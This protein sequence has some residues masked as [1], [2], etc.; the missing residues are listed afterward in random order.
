MVHAVGGLLHVDAVQGPGKIVCDIGALGADLMT[1]SAHKL[2]GPKGV[3][4]VVTRRD[5]HLTDPMIRGGGQERGARAG[6]ENVAGIAGFGAAAAAAGEGLAEAGAHMAALRERL[7]AGLRAISPDTALFGASVARLPNTASFAVP[8]MKAETA[9]IALDL[10]GLAVSS[11]SACSS[12]KVSASHVLAAMGVE[13]DLAR[14]AIR[15]SLGFSSS[16]EDV[17]RFLNAWNRLARTLLKG[18]HGIAA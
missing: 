4:A 11:G 2:G 15:V 1:L 7:E 17:D 3:G 10:D 8:G 6:T 12:G 13:P 9:L 18:T 14:G 5:L 16:E